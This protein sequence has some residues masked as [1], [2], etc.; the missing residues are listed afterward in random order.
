MIGE[1]GQAR[2]KLSAKPPAIDALKRAISYFTNHEER[3]NY[4]FY[5][6]M[7]KP[8]GS[9]VTEAACKSVVKERLCGSGMKWT[10]GG[11]EN[12][13]TLRALTKSADRWEQ[14]WQKASRFGFAKIS[15]PKRS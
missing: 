15:A 8:I 13:L 14:F 10:I 5:Q 2:D 9:G 12:T 1:F 4:H 6:A 7:G 3:M 11:A